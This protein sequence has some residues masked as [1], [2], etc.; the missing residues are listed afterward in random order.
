ME[1]TK[2]SIVICYNNDYM[3]DILTIGKEYKVEEILDE[4]LMRVVGVSEPVFI[5]R[6]IN[7]DT[8]PSNHS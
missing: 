8:L 4:D 3:T 7:P 2:G 1:L 6:F 5:W